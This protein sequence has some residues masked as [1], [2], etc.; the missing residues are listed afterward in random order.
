M[1]LIVIIPHSSAPPPQENCKFTDVAEVLARS[2]TVDMWDRPKDVE[3]FG[4]R[5]CRLCV[6][7]SIMQNVLRATS[8]SASL[9][10][11]DLKLVILV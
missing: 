7:S 5:L 3:S 10:L 1:L 11:L 4:V 8:Y 9:I 2:G 6:T